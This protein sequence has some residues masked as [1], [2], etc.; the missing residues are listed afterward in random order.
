M[1]SA[2]E[3]IL[4]VAD[5]SETSDAANGTHP[6]PRGRMSR[7]SRSLLAVE[8]ALALV[9]LL[10]ASQ[11]SAVPAFA[12]KYGLHC[13][14]CHEAWPALNDFGRAFRDDGYQLLQ[15]KDD[16]TTATPGY[17]PLSI[18]LT[19]HYEFNMASRQPTDQGTTTLKSGGVSNIGLDLLLAGTLF[20][21]V[22][23]LVVPTG[24]TSEEG[25]SLEAAWVR[26]SN[27]GGSSWAN[28]KLGKHDVDLPRASHRT[29]TL[30]ETGY[31]IYRYHSPGSV[32]AYDLGENQRGIEWVGHDRGSFTRAAISLFNVE[33]SPGTRS[34]FDTPG[35]YAHV[36]REW[37]FDSSGLSAFR[38]GGFGS[39]TTWPTSTLTQNSEPIPR[40]G[41]DLKGSSKV[42][43]D[44]H[45]WFGPT[46]TPLHLIM[47]F[48]HGQDDRALI[49]DATRDGAFNGGFVELGYTPTLRTTVFGRYDAIRNHT[50]GVADHPQHLNDED[51]ATVGLRHTFN[52]TSRAEYALH[53]ELSTMRTKLAAADD[54]DVRNNTLFLG[55]DFAF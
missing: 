8:G 38:I 45:L 2:V 25:V 35:V 17:L 21:N 30:S 37:L 4:V 46:V 41:S 51:A 22:S 50:Q 13:T 54:S 52:F 40:Q 27:L 20:D 28:L 24:F 26:F 34:A 18:R 12:R 53:A 16:P 10:T 11:A 31:L 5:F 7:K 55:I 29:W 47:V 3:R 44:A 36:T 14:A 49:P 6:C 23:F 43:L 9:I 42:G 19:P 32:S 1:T 48:A 39:Y 15:G 33:G